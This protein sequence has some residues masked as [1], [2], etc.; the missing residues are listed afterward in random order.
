MQLSAAFLNDLTRSLRS[1]AA[2]GVDKRRRPRVGVR[3]K[4]SVQFTREG[5]SLLEPIGVRDI[6]AGGI[7]FSCH[8]PLERGERIILIL[9]GDTAQSVACEIS[10]CRR[11]ASGVYQVGAKF[12]DAIPAVPSIN[13]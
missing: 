1:N 10:H 8:K 11:V 12:A 3:L 5:Q 9:A 4:A 7:G 13:K 6:S 2:T